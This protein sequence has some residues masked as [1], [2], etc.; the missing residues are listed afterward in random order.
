[1]E[2]VEAISKVKL[3]VDK[4]EETGEE[5][6]TNRPEKD[7]V[8]KTITIEKNGVNYEKPTTLEPFDYY[9]W[10]LQTYYGN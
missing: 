8:I 2:T 7:V 3:A 4:D 10:Y 1:M 5:T 9:S 6:Q